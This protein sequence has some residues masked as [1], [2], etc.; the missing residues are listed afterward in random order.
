[1]LLANIKKNNEPGIRIGM[2]RGDTI[3]ETREQENRTIVQTKSCEDKKGK[4]RGE[5]K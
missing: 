2:D 5:N 3:K 1:M 4:K